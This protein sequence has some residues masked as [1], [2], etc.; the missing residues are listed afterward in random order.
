MIIEFFGPPG[1]G[2]TTIAQ[3]LA[4]RLKKEYIALAGRSEKR[5]YLWCSLTRSP[6]RFF[7]LLIKTLWSGAH[8]WALWWHKLFLLSEHLAVNE[9][10]WRL[11][12]RGSVILDGGLTQYLLTLHE[13]S[14][15]EV[16]LA[17]Y[18]GRCLDCQVL[19][20]VSAPEPLRSERMRRRG[21]F[22]RAGLSEDHQAWQQQ[23]G[24]QTESLRSFF[25]A[26][27]VAG[28]LVLVFDSS[29]EPAEQIVA[30]LKGEIEPV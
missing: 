14:A 25:D 13:R 2:K 11:G 7:W 9:K 30:K 1:S 17:T 29:L 16:E 20:I 24:R 28:L 22:P 5:L 8:S 19:V 21:R 18:V 23:L 27:P 4:L 3:Q 15:S 10:A 26:K 12:R 6:G